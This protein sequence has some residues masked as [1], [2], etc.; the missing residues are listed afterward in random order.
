MAVHTTTMI[1]T[2]ASGQTASAVLTLGGLTPVGVI[3]PGA[4]TGTSLTFNGGAAPGALSPVHD[5]DAAYSVAAGASR[6]IA[7]EPAALYPWEYLQIVSSGAEAAD[8]TLTLV[9]R[10]V[11][12]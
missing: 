7:L 8:R 6:A 1:V 12:G 3:T 9:L 11:G 2:I 5:G 4:L 10:K